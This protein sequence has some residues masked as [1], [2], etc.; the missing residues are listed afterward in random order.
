VNRREIQELLSSATRL[1][2]PSSESASADAQLILAHALDCTRQWLR[3][4]GDAEITPEQRLRFE[5]LCSR[6][7]AGEPIAYI[8]GSAGFYGREFLVNEQV[9]IP[10]P[11]TEHLVDETLAFVRGG[12]RVLDVGTGCGAIAC[13]VA[14]ETEAVVDATDVSPDAIEVARRNADRLNV[15]ARCHFYCGDLA[16]PL[17]P[18]RYDAVIANLPYI[19]TPDLPSPPS[20][21]SFEPRMALDGGS[22]GLTLY[23]E[24]LH[25]L[26]P[27]LDEEALILLE[28]APPTMENLAILARTTFPDF[29]IEIKT[30]Y[31][32]LPRYLKI[33]ALPSLG[34]V[35]RRR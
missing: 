23:R 14:A 11:E 15:A 18:Q 30:D 31:A 34:A 21:A 16:A 13:T 17:T 10:R 24:L 9:L 1:L 8:L 19:P 32:N 7:R 20:P 12:M 33:L 26:P 27:L 35:R 22:D 2:A 6:R 29:A 25:Q 5:Q 4:N 3:A 28:A